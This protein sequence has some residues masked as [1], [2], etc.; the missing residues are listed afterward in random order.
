MN[1]YE[2]SQ[3]LL[4]I[5]NEVEENG[6]ELTEELEKALTITQADL[7]QKVRDYASVIKQ[8]DLDIA[9]IDKEVKRLKA[10]KESKARVKE[11][12]SAILATSIDMFGEHTKSGGAYV[13]LGDEKVSVRNTTKVEVDTDTVN[14]IAKDVMNTYSNLAWTNSWDEANLSIQSFIDRGKTHTK[15]DENGEEVPNPINIVPENYKDI[16][17]TIKLTMPLSKLIG[18]DGVEFAKKLLVTGAV[19]SVEGSVSKTDMK[20]E[21][22]STNTTENNIAKLVNNKTISIR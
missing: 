15:T 6:G 14:A 9:G 8:V 20:K 7:K 11:R 4:D 17:A 18:Y 2:I 21:F 19:Y 22:V 3:A 5:Y 16:N 10:Y 13:D 12:L 1:I